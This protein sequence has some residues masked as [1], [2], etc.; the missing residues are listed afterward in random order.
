MLCH[1]A[2]KFKQC[3]M[4]HRCHSGKASSDIRA[5]LP[6]PVPTASRHLPTPFTHF[7]YFTYGLTLTSKTFLIDWEVISFVFSIPM[8]ISI[9]PSNQSLS[10]NVSKFY[11][12]D[13]VA[14]RYSF[15][16]SP[17]LGLWLVL[18]FRIF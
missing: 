17:G 18:Q 4:R 12:G 1:S 13:K 2:S 8:T 7:P 5:Q 6:S 14:R 15:H 16:K 9:H 3:R 11:R 10:K